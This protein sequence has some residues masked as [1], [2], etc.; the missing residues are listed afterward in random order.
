MLRDWLG[1][2]LGIRYCVLTTDVRGDSQQA[3]D[4]HATYLQQLHWQCLLLRGSNIFVL[5]P[6]LATRPE[7]DGLPRDAIAVLSAQVC[8]G[9]GLHQLPRQGKVKRADI[10]SVVPSH[11]WHTTTQ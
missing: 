11:L 10:V 7:L 8:F 2:Q 6:D 9:R 3:I 4:P 5:H 1:L